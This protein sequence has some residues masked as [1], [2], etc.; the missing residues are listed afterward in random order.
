MENDKANARKI[1]YLLGDDLNAIKI[2][3]W[4]G[5]QVLVSE[6][7]LSE[8]N[9]KNNGVDTIE[10]TFKGEKPRYIYIEELYRIVSSIK[11]KP[12]FT[13]LKEV[14]TKQEAVAAPNRKF[15]FL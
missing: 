6:G 9:K 1:D 7:K 15:S 3:K 5:D 14:A 8:E 10:R 12:F 4:S 2:E 13:P 11:A